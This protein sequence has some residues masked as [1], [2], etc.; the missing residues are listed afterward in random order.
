MKEPLD[1]KLRRRCV[2][3]GGRGRN[4]E[5][6]PCETCRGL[7]WVFMSRL[8][9]WSRRKEFIGRE[10]PGANKDGY[11]KWPRFTAEVPPELVPLLEE[12]QRKSLGINW[13]GNLDR[14]RTA[15]RANLVTA[16]LRMYLEALDPEEAL[17]IDVTAEEIEEED[18]HRYVRSIPVS[19]RSSISSV[20]SERLR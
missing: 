18:K 13:D 2:M 11:E 4:P 14:P 19:T 9:A 8:A 3:C 16:A 17:P 12:A 7:G 1:K 10:H 20:N 6:E 15:T 5:N